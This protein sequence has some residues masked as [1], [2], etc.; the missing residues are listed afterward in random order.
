MPFTA[1][2][3]AHQAPG[4]SSAA[5]DAQKSE[6]EADARLLDAAREDALVTGKASPDLS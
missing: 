6:E 4:P 3:I 2:L 1:S 5:E